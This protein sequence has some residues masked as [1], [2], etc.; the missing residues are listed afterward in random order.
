[1]LELKMP[2]A[3]E[4]ENKSFGSS[5]V[6]SITLADGSA[7][8]DGYPLAVCTLYR[9]QLADGSACYRTGAELRLWYR[10]AMAPVQSACDHP[11]C[12]RVAKFTLDVSPTDRYDGKL[13]ICAE[14]LSVVLADCCKDTPGGVLVKNYCH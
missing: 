10:D 14:H 8:L 13:R 7:P 3:K 1:M 9:V 6:L 11:N 12:Q 4:C 5:G 2:T